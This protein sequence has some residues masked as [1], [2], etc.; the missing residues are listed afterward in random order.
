MSRI[1]GRKPQGLFGLVLRAV[2]FITRRKLG[3]VVMPVQ[4]TAHHPRLLL[5]GVGPMEQALQGSQC[6]ELTLKELCSIR[7]ATL[8]GCPF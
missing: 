8:V 4:V 7:V 6:V 3:K 5:L 2:Y 1:E